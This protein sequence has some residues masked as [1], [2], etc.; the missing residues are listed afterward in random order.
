M[1]VGEQVINGDSPSLVS[2][3]CAAYWLLYPSS[4]HLKARRRDSAQEVILC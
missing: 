1:V 3:Q 4:L 2:L